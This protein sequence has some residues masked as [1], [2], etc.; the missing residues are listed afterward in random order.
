MLSRTKVITMNPKNS[1]FV[2]IA[3]V[4]VSPGKVDDYLTIAAEA[5]SAVKETEPGMLMHNFDADPDDPLQF[6]WTEIYRDDESLIAHIN[7]PPVQEYGKK[8]LKLAE[9]IEVEIYGTLA[10]ETVDYL[11]RTWGEAGI[12]FKY[13]KTTDVGYHRGSAFLLKSNSS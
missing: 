3:R 12:P 1:P 13:F 2:L 8:H 9:S 10:D 11:N 6:T 7:N 5:D 4:R